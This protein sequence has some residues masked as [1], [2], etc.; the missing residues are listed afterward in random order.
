MSTFG[1]TLLG[2]LLCSGL[3]GDVSSADARLPS[4]VKA[5][6]KSHCFKCH[7]PEKQKGKIRLDTLSTDF[8]KDRAAAETWHDTMNVVQIGE[9]PPDDEPDLTSEQRKVLVDWIRGKLH[10][11]AKAQKVGGSG[12]VMRRLNNTEYR[13]TLTDLLGV[14]ADYGAELPSDPLSKDGFLNNGEAL[15]MSALQLE[16]YLQS[17][18][19]AL[20]SVLVEGAQPERKS[21]IEDKPMNLRGLMDGESSERLGRYHFF[22]MEVKD[23]PRS[24]R[25]VIRVTARADL[26]EGH[27]APFIQV[28]YGNHISGAKPLIELVGESRVTSEEAKIYEFSGWAE[29]FPIIPT[30]GEKLKQVLAVKNSLDDAVRPAKPIKE[31]RKKMIYPEDDA[32]PKVI[33][34][35]VEFVANDHTSWPPEAHRR[36]IDRAANEDI[37]VALNRFL[38]RAWRRPVAQSE[39]DTYRQHFDRMLAD[40]GMPI[41]A[42]RETLA[43]ALSAPQFLYL[44]EPENKAEARRL[45]DHELAARLSYFLWSSSPDDELMRLADDRQLHDATVLRAEVKRLFADQKSERFIEEFVTQ[46]LDLTGVNRVA[47]NPEF[48]PDFDTALE[49]SMSRESHLFFREVVLSDESALKLLDADFIMVNAALAKHYGLEGPRSQEFVRVAL[50]DSG[51]PGGLLAHGAMHLAN[52]NGEDSHP[53]KRAVWVLE[54]LLHDPP[55]PP[56]PNVPGLDPSN[57]DFARLSVSEQLKVHREDP[58]CGDC[59]RGID[60]WGLALENFDAVGQWRE[61]IRKPGGKR[62][63][64]SKTGEEMGAVDARTT[65]PGGHQIDGVTGLQKFLLNE[66]REQFAH[67]FVHKLATYALGRSLDL[68]DEPQVDRLAR[69]FAKNDHSIKSLIE[70]IVVSELFRN[71]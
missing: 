44:I 14:E 51:R 25:F 50:A 4:S 26:V 39:L 17:A 36:I 71:R 46:W 45:N 32:F 66:R 18:R 12:A 70:E 34:E 63:R 41:A 55:A 48:Y 67:A 5:V 21:Q 52:S 15:G 68:S 43:V 47:V 60:P 16:Y 2:W 54:R 31:K 28:H 69:Q 59:H 13:Y 30:K 56:P 61:V 7:G 38:R 62:R 10:A 29:A 9:M 24:G 65:L 33:I 40:T 37:D 57:P 6:L 1:K 19:K 64:K 22:G 8:I 35:S 20:A 42:L 58:A 23:P 3:V 27:V 49:S 53:I 11:A